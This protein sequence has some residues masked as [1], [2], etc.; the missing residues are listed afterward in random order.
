M[1]AGLLFI[2]FPLIAITEGRHPLIIAVWFCLAAVSGLV[3]GFKLLWLPRN[4]MAARIRYE[5]DVQY[6]DRRTHE[7]TTGEELAAG[8]SICSPNGRHVLRM[9]LHGNVVEWGD[10][11][12]AM[13]KTATEHSGEDNYLTLK[14]GGELVVCR[15]DGSEVKVVPGTEKCG[16][17]KLILQDDAQLVL[18]RPDDSIA[19]RTDRV[20]G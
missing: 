7:L 11:M 15:R 6:V 4:P 10:G 17:T 8:R 3:A 9:G 1:S 16:G 18:L 13:W 12:L 14:P 2:G 20:I 19:W 5:Y